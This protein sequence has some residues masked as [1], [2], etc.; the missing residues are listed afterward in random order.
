MVSSRRANTIFF[1]ATHYVSKS[2]LSEYSDVGFPMVAMW[3]LYGCS[4]IGH[5]GTTNDIGYIWPDL[6]GGS[7]INNYKKHSHIKCFFQNISANIIKHVV[8]RVSQ[9]V[10]L[11]D[12]QNWQFSSISCFTFDL[13]S[14]RLFFSRCLFFSR[15]LSPLSSFLPGRLQGDTCLHWENWFL[16][17]T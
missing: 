12:I 7:S 5:I 6:F 1:S 16:E 8:F 9:S 11:S 15:R 4:L 3:W 14:G 17:N 13:F 2:N 10:P